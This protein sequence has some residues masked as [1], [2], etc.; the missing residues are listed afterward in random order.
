[1]GKTPKSNS[2]PSNLHPILWSNF[3][4]PVGKSC[5][6]LASL[7]NRSRRLFLFYA[8][9]SHFIHERAFFSGLPIAQPKGYPPF[10]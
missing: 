4:K 6:P 9:F 8:D 5:F 7:G 1:M 3:S 2:P 10:P